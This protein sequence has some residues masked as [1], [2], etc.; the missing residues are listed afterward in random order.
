VG[1]PGVNAGADHV[2]S[3]P[4]GLPEVEGCLRVLLAGPG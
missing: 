1:P 4:F 3:K 2:L